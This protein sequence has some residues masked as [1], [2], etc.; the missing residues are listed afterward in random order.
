[1]SAVQTHR[2]DGVIL[3]PNAHVVIALQSI[4]GI[5]KT[6]ANKICLA[7]GIPSSKKVSELSDDEFKLLQDGV[8]QYEV[9][10]PLR[11]R[12]A[13]AKQHLKNIRC[14]RGK[15]HANRLPSRGQRTRTNAATAKGTAGKTGQQK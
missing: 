11:R 15:R 5:G 9:E 12:V 4:F 1:M 3:R 7:S 14:Y 10:G 8:S 6:R 2:I 13:S